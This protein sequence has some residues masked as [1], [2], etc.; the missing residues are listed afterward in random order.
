MALSRHDCTWRYKGVPGDELPR[1]VAQL[2]RIPRDRL[3]VLLSLSPSLSLRSF[4]L[5]PFI[6]ILRSSYSPTNLYDESF[7][8]SYPTYT[9]TRG[10]PRMHCADAAHTRAS[11]IRPKVLEHTRVIRL[12]FPVASLRYCAR[13]TGNVFSQTRELYQ[14]T[15][16]GAGK[17]GK[18]DT[19]SL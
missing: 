13:G 2:L 10:S 6:P 14:S 1:A 16:G 9:Y 7:V 5:L 11:Q 3:Q 15:L 8:H 12:L 18:Y 4:P 19:V 17:H